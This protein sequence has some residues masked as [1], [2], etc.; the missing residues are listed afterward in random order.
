MRIHADPDPKLCNER[1]LFSLSPPPQ[2][3]KLLTAPLALV[4]S[5]IIPMHRHVGGGY[6]HCQ[7][8][9]AN[10]LGHMPM[11][12]RCLGYDFRAQEYSLFN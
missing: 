10:I 4:E 8:W 6:Q 5:C 2:G 7:R 12:I 11:L 1:G 9:H 3:L